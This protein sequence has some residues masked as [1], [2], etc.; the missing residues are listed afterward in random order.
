MT[1][2][3]KITVAEWRKR[4]EAGEDFVV[5]DTRNPQEWG[6]SDVKIPEAIR[7]TADKLDEILSNI[8]KDKPVV[9]YCT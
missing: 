6:K 2:S 7:V 4:M 8:P 9:A 5:I 1:D 3:Q